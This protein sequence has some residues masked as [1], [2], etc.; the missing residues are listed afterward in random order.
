M[1]D[2]DLERELDREFGDDERAKSAMRA[3]L[4]AMH[5]HD[6]TD[7]AP[8]HTLIARKV[9]TALRDL[10]IGGGQMLVLGQDAELFAGVPVDERRLP[11]GERAGFTAT[12]PATV[13]RRPGL[14]PHP[15]LR[16]R[17][18]HGG[19]G[20]PDRYDVVVAV[21]GYCDVA[22][23]RADAVA[24]R[25]VEQILGLVGCLANTEPGG[26]TV[27]LVSHDVMDGPDSDARRLL[28]EFGELVGAV[29]LP[30]GALREDPGTDAVVDLLVLR[31]HDGTPLAPHQ[32][33]RAPTRTVGGQW[34]R[35][36]DY[37]RHN[38]H[39]VLGRLSAR[40]TPWGQ[41]ELVVHASG[42]G[43]NRDL[44]AGLAAV[45]AHARRTGLTAA[46]ERSLDVDAPIDYTLVHHD[47]LDSARREISRLRDAASQEPQIPGPGPAAPRPDD[48]I[49]PTR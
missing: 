10:G 1:F 41:A 14:A 3:D 8:A 12:I 33:L 21:P 6:T 25:R 38:P 17:A 26:F 45:T 13:P 15:N 46:T 47:D 43:L 24:S 5:D 42:L 27:G 44:T 9:W 7:T 4:V 30:S 18:W 40:A 19:S 23:H 32:F 34:V 49:G 36:N 29:R 28:T 2:D 48:G 11:P 31:R 22:L 39:Q 35:V 37:F 16:L 20:D